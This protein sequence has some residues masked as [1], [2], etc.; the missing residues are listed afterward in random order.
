[1]DELLLSA[2]RLKVVA[3]LLGAPWVS[4]P[5]LMRATESTQG[6]LG[7]HLTRLVDGGYVAEQKRFVGRRPSTRYRIT[8]RGRR[9]FLDHVETLRRIADAANADEAAG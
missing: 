8:A 3:E 4:F 5:E 9:A 2:V 6:N 1:M 7:A